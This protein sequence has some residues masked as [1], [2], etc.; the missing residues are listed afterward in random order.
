[1]ED[2]LLRK[3]I[4]SLKL[5]NKNKA[6]TIFANDLSF[7]N[8]IYNENVHGFKLY[9]YQ[10]FIVY[11]FS[12]YGT[13][14][15]MILKWGT[16]VGKTKTSLVC[17]HNFLANGG[18]DV[19]VIGLTKSI[20]IKE[21]VNDPKFG[22]STPDILEELKYS[23][24]PT[25]AILKKAIG[26][27]YS[28]LGYEKL[29]NE[30]FIFN[31]KGTDISA[32]QI[33]TYEEL[34]D[35]VDRGLYTINEEMIIKLTNSFIILDEMQNLYNA[36]SK[37]SYGLVVKYILHRLKENV[38]CIGLSAT[39][40]NSYPSEIVDVASIIV[41]DFSYTKDD[42]FETDGITL[43]KGC[44]EIIYKAFYGKISYLET[45][46]ENYPRQEFMGEAIKGIDYLKFIRCLMV[47]PQLL[48]Y[49]K[50]PK[51]S[52]VSDCVFLETNKL[53]TK[54][55]DKYS[56]FVMKNPQ[57]QGA[58]YKKLL[59]ILNK[60]TL[61]SVIY[62]PKIGGTG[63]LFIQEMLLANGYT[64]YGTFPSSH[65][66]CIKCKVRLED[67]E[68]KKCQSFSPI[69]IA[70]AAGYVS[71]K[72]RNLI[73][74]VF[75]SPENTDGQIITI[76]LGS[77]V[78]EE[79]VDMK[80]VRS[81]FIMKK[82]KNLGKF[83]QLNGRPIRNNSHSLLPYEE[84]EVK[85]YIFV[86]SLPKGVESYE[87]HSYKK[88]ITRFNVTKKINSVLNSCSIDLL[89][90]YDI[91]D[92]EG[93]PLADDKLVRPKDF[94]HPIKFDRSFFDTM[95]YEKEIINTEAIILAT[96]NI[97][98]VWKLEDL[99]IEVKSTPIDT[100]F[101][102]AFIDDNNIYIALNNLVGIPIRDKI[103]VK[104]GDFYILTSHLA[105]N[106]YNFLS[107]MAIGLQKI[108]LEDK[109]NLGIE[110]TSHKES[111]YKENRDLSILKISFNLEKY[112]RQF[113]IQFAQEI[114]EY[115]FGILE[116]KKFSERHDFMMRILYFYDKFN[117]ILFASQIE[118]DKYAKYTHTSASSN[119]DS[120][121][122]LLYTTTLN[123][124]SHKPVFVKF[125]DIL[126]QKK[127][128]PNNLPIGHYLD[129]KP[130][131]FD[132]KNWEPYYFKTSRIVKPKNDIVIG[133]LERGNGIEFE[134]KLRFPEEEV[135]TDNRLKKKGTKCKNIH[136]DNLLSLCQKLGIE[137]S[138]NIVNICESIKSKLIELELGKTG[139][140]WFYFHFEDH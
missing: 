98:P 82:P 117:L 7:M 75:S 16:G 12:L 109:L 64:E 133:Y 116:G 114:I 57:D 137:N 129:I 127:L 119:I 70:T 40:V 26:E 65:S 77:P 91:I 36:K 69:Y 107:T 76:L 56:A 106:N 104:R 100:Q 118:G 110:Y 34:L 120:Y 47:G 92:N 113:H 112:S 20:F 105:D 30:V 97:S 108:N 124:I 102:P 85:I 17:A 54:T 41:P 42:L 128:H 130:I 24:K 37:N 135:Y 51:E 96:F 71:Q 13:V 84:R 25:M 81:L 122:H 31:H 68:G 32:P 11:Y 59:D 50:N 19:F 45:R 18:K 52:N 2:I 101:N 87:E 62:H 138:D 22:F 21:L 115:I 93:N 43:K 44:L 136:K 35:S 88:M 72:K 4:Y 111:F 67:H 94:P 38:W 14:K 134:F 10:Q 126:A 103:I 99:I 74:S 46:G 66:I 49:N 28:F 86:A 33:N 140:R 9:S 6:K 3:E 80:S 5:P 8:Q 55:V 89:L 63:I 121:K 95:F 15:R 29:F 27:H 125:N 131:I 58:K 73:F 78:I 1:M 90:N 48:A 60:E 132:G 61:K 23:Y 123:N 39:L 53:E 139:L 79:S 83:L